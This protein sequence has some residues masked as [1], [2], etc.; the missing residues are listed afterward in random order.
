[1]DSKTRHIKMFS[2]SAIVTSFLAYRTVIE[3]LSDKGKIPPANMLHSKSKYVVRESFDLMDG[4]R[5]KLMT[6]MPNLF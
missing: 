4:S 3:C 2:L 5:T 1:M 6:P